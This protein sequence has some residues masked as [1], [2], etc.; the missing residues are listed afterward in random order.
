VR[1]ITEEN[2]H[3]KRIHLL[4]LVPTAL[5]LL[6]IHTFD[7]SIERLKLDTFG[8]DGLLYHVI[9]SLWYSLKIIP[10][11]YFIAAT[12]TVWRY[13][14]M[15]LQQHSVVNE[16]ALRWLYYLTLGFVLAGTWTLLVTILVY[17]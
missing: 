10:L 2:F 1:S 14:K 7:I 5:V 12:L 8:M 3:I 4:H 15:L 17:F 6:V 13:H 9:D 16:T 11:A